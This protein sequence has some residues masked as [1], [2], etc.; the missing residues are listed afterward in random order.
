[1]HANIFEVTMIL[2]PGIGCFVDLESESKFVYKLSMI[3]KSRMLL[4]NVED[5]A[6]K[7]GQKGEPY[8]HY[9]HLYFVFVLVYKFNAD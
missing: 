5:N 7:L 6:S 2:Q 4:P 1:M 8:R 3:K 9:K